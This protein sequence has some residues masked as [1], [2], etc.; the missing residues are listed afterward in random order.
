LLANESESTNQGDSLQTE[1]LARQNLAAITDE[2]TTEYILDRLSASDMDNM[3]QNFPQILRTI[4]EKYTNMNK[5]KFIE[6]VKSKQ[7][8]TNEFELSERGQRRAS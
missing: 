5:N 3:N 4:K 6:I 1:N 7:S 8:Y 2:K